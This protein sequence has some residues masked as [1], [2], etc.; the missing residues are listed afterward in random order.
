MEEHFPP[1][2][3]AGGREGPR[4]GQ[5]GN[6]RP[7]PWRHLAG[8][9]DRESSHHIKGSGLADLWFSG[10]EPASLFQVASGRTA[11]RPGLGRGGSGKAWAGELLSKSRVEFPDPG[12]SF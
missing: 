8:K 4:R 10:A 11:A 6:G 3:G 7:R 2:R 12:A 1:G 5:C 9:G